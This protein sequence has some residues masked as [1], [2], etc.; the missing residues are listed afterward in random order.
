MVIHIAEISLNLES[1]KYRIYPHTLY[2]IKYF[3]FFIK[4]YFILKNINI[5]EFVRNEGTLN[6]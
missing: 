6:S 1:W 2:V 3:L 4:W 5:K